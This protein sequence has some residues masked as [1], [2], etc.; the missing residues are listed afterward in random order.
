MQS[1]AE[2]LK[3]IS[4]LDTSVVASMLATAQ[5]D[6]INA[7][8]RLEDLKGYL[9]T[10]HWSDDRLANEIA[11]LEKQIAEREESHAKTM[12]VLTKQLDLYRKGSGQARHDIAQA[13]SEA[14]QSIKLFNVLL[15]IAKT[16]SILD[17]T[18][19]PDELPEV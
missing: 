11:A 2:I 5:Q 15:A 6:A 10:A 17:V 8:A 16:K 19:V 4:S 13:R 3:A 1:Q 7:K 9:V 18:G 12:K 14:N